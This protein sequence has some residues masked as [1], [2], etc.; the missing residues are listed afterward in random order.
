MKTETFHNDGEGGEYVYGWFCYDCP[1]GSDG[2]ESEGDCWH[3]SQK[4]ETAC[5]AEE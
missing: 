5:P 1:A 3:D 2:W 4:H